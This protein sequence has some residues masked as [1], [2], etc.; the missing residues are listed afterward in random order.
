MARENETYR[1]ELEQLLA[2]FGG[3]K[4]LTVT[5]VAGYVGHSRE[6]CRKHFGISG[7]T[8]VTVTKLAHILSSR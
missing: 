3:H 4:I 7:K 8:G 6:W 5:D 2:T 1:L